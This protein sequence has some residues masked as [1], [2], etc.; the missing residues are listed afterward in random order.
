VTTD[1]FRVS[2]LLA[3]R[4]EERGLS[5]P[6]VLQVAGLPAGF[7][8]PEKIFATTEEL[9]ALWRAIAETSREPVIGL[10]LGAETRIEQHDPAAIAALCSQSFA[11]AL[12]RMA[13]YKQLTCPEEIRIGPGKDET[14]VEFAWLLAR[15]AEPAVLVDVC[16]SWIL[17]IGRRGTG[18]P[19][20]P[21]RLELARAS[22]QRRL[23]EGH[24][25]CRVQ[26]KA[27]R[28]ALV[29]RT[30]DLARPFVTHNAELLAILGPQ[31][32]RELDARESAGTLGDRVKATIKRLLAGQRPSIHLVARRLG[33]SSRTLQRRLTDGGATF[34]ELI[35]EARRELAR[36]Y[37]RQGALEL[38]ETAYLLGYVDANSFFR[39]FHHWEGT[40]PGEWRSRHRP[41]GAPA[42]SR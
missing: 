12:R 41:A 6:A 21:V 4:L 20:N 16:L 17:A 14:T 23:L 3:R 18:N 37:L 32:E 38:N 9:F 22:A 33:M 15:E 11:D 39:A 31:L 29:F 7:F 30:S 13:R 42:S 25:G 27:D 36:H 40:T 5:L 28:N 2:G 19:L 34:Q 8:E 26:F 1:R 35:E 10:K 24:F